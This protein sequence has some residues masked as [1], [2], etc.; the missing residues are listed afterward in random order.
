[1][2]VLKALAITLIE[3]VGVDGHNGGGMLLKIMEMELTD[4]LLLFGIVSIRIL[5]PDLN[6]I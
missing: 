5:F 3:S 1:M 2:S 6:T 4:F